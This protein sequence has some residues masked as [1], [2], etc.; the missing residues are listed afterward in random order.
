MRAEFIEISN[1]QI[2]EGLV[3]HGTDFK[4]Y[5]DYDGK[6]LENFEQENDVI[7]F[8]F[9]NCQSGSTINRI[10]ESKHKY[11]KMSYEA[12]KVIQTR[13]VKDL[14]QVGNW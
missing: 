11:K 6:P 7:L 5:S 13:D 14:S 3:G 4:I 2:T 12:N 1:N 8:T 10:R 9:W